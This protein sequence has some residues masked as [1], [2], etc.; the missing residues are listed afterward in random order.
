MLCFSHT[1]QIEAVE[2]IALLLNAPW[3]KCHDWIAAVV[4]ETLSVVLKWMLI[5]LLVSV[6]LSV[7]LKQSAI[8]Y[9]VNANPFQ[10][11]CH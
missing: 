10:A 4:T 9:I 5:E 11:H 2:Q 1:L 6:V 3:H 7:V 8:A